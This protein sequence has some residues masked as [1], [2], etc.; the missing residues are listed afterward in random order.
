MSSRTVLLEPHEWLPDFWTKFP[1]FVHK[2]KDFVSNLAK[3]ANI[4]WS[5]N[6]REK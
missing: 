5:R 2:D 6:V 4:I 1:E 3:E